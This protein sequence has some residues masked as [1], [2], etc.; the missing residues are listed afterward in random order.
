M[1]WITHNEMYYCE[2]KVEKTLVIGDKAV[3]TEVDHFE[4]IVQE[5]NGL[6][7]RT[8]YLNGE[9]YNEFEFVEFHTALITGN[10]WHWNSTEPC[11]AETMIQKITALLK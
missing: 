8:T 7:T 11:D 6:W 9:Y 4:V 3:D 2:Y 10:K 5:E 1:E